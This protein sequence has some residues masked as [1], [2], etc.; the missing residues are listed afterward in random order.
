[1]LIFGHR[2]APGFPRRGENT[3]A[4]FRTALERG[5]GGLELDVRRCGDGTIV[6]IHDDTVDRTTSGRGRVRD[7]SYEQLRQFDAGWGDCIPRLSDVLDN[8]ASRCLLNIELKE[9]GLGADVARLVRGRGLQR[10]VLISAFDRDDAGAGSDCSWEEL[11]DLAPDI[12]IALIC[13]RARLSVIGT[14]SLVSQA[15]RLR[16]SAVHPQIGSNLA[17]LLPSARDA[18]L[19]V[20]V[21]TVNSP[22]D[23]AHLRELGADGIFTD[24]PEMG[25]RA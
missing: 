11:A 3:A 16:A 17:A 8:F 1:M 14:D 4:S 21:W 13:S 25:V 22:A 18:G 10:N 9:S 24:F 7:L 2:G 5:A 6:A 23:I 20:H 15:L 19:R 12:A